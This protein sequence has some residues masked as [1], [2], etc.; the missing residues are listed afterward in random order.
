MN[1][2]ID[3]VI[4]G[5]VYR[6][7]SGQWDNDQSNRMCVPVVD[8]SGNLWMQDTYQIQRPSMKPEEDTVTDAQIRVMINYGDGEHYWCLKHAHGT[9]Y[10]KNQK[11]ITSEDELNR[12]ELVADLRNYRGL[13]KGE[14]Y[15]D[16]KDDDV[17]SGIKL[18]FEHGYS[19]T[20]GNIGVHLVRKDAVKNNVSMLKKHIQDLYRT[21]ERPYSSNFRANYVRESLKCVEDTAENS[22]I[23]AKAKCA[24]MLHEKLLEMRKEFEQFEADVEVELGLKRKDS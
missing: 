9:F 23:N 7:P 21:M 22:E 17:V 12:Y 14:D 1:S 19:W 16:Y 5:G 2:L 4:F 10:N 24:L 8:E 20:Y 6:V 11:M 15:R 13:K 3:K 18:F